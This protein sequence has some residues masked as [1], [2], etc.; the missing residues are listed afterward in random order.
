MHSS[1]VGDHTSKEG[2]DSL[3]TRVSMTVKVEM[4]PSLSKDF[5]RQTTPT[6]MARCSGRLGYQQI[7]RGEERK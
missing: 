7:S 5:A 3:M 4:S 2:F 6:N 1:E